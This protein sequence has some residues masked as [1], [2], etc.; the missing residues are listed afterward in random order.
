MASLDDE[1]LDLIA[2]ESLVDRGRLTR[3]ATLAD[4]GLDSVDIITIVFAVEEK[5]AVQIPENAFAETRDL[6]GL[7]DIMKALIEK[8]AV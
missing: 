1:L 2:A 3:D 8:P 4:V 5:Y 7:L 6:G